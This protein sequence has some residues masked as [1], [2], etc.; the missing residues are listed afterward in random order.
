MYLNFNVSVVPQPHCSW[1]RGCGGTRNVL[2]LNSLFEVT[3]SRSMLVPSYP[4]TS[5][6]DEVKEAKLPKLQLFSPLP[7]HYDDDFATRS[8]LGEVVYKLFQCATHS[9]L[10]QF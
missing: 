10:V 6:L 3:G 7:R 2:F 5:S 8:S 4:R 9:L 1:V